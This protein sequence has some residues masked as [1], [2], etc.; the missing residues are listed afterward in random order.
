MP[1]GLL[2]II[3]LLSVGYILLLLELFVPGGILGVLGGISI[4]YGCLKAFSLG[5]LWGFAALGL[6]VV[7]TLVMVR[8]F[9]KSRAAKRLVLSGEEQRTWKGQD[10][11][12]ADFLGKQGRTT[13][14]LRPAGLAEIDGERVDV[15]SDS[16]FLDA[17]VL[18]QVV[19]VEGNRVVVEAVE[20]LDEAAE[21]SPQATEAAIGIPES[22]A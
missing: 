9:L 8:T 11:S 7:V 20:E 5:A 22:N 17:G 3:A 19:E 4:L 1:E 14:L 12:L 13:S 21:E 2:E 6:S 10:T 18:V 15:V 16:E